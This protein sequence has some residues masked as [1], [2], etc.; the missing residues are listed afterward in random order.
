MSRNPS[1]PGLRIRLQH[2][3]LATEIL[4]PDL[5]EPPSLRPELF[6]TRDFARHN[7]AKTSLASLVGRKISPA[8]S[9]SGE[10]NQLRY[11]ATFPKE[12]A[13]HNR[14]GIILTK[15]KYIVYCALVVHEIF[16]QASTGNVLQYSHLS[17]SEIEIL[18]GWKSGR[19]TVINCFPDSW[20]DR[21]NSGDMVSAY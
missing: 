16:G 13:S 7:F 12:S 2:L 19:W 9:A 14:A 10:E 11:A 17:F 6:Q 5:Q 4:P 15:K 8:A 21:M 18:A 20:M 3:F 1:C